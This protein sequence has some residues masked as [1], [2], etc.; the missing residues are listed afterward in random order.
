MYQGGNMWSAWDSYLTAGRDVL[1]LRLPSHA[2]YRSWEQVAIHGGFRIMHSEFCM[3]SD[4]PEV[5]QVDAGNRP[6]CDNGPS[7]RWRDGW[8]LWYWHGVAV[9]EQIIM[10]P[11]TLCAADVHA[12]NDVEVRRVMVERM[13]WDRYA[14]QAGVRVIHADALESQFPTIPVSDLIEPSQRLVISYRA[15]KETAELL[16]CTQQTD[17]E[18]RPI[19]LVRLTDPSTGRRYT[20][21][22][23]HDTQRCY[24][25]VAASF[26]MTEKQYRSGTYKRQGDVMLK[27][28]A[29][30]V[31]QTHS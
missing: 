20:L 3:V 1:G 31:D 29:R 11:E 14:E 6:H 22:V 2:A 26:G 23:A 15:G 17:F 16:E 21:R 25:G 13:G 12:E 28:L 24:E 19:R 8:S 30:K 9:T 27:S 5:I 18:G 4:F 7:H 10:R